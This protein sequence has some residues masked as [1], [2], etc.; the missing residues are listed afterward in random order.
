MNTNNLDIKNSIDEDISL[1]TLILK[2][3]DWWR[4]LVSRW[5]F[6]LIVGFIG[7]VLGLLYSIFNKPTFVATLTFV[8]EDDSKNGLGSLGGLAAMTGINL[9]GGGGGVF[10]GDNILELY[11]SRTMLTSALLNSSNRNDSLLIDRYIEVNN[12][13]QQWINNSS[14]RNLDFT[15]PKEDFSF[16]HDS[17]IGVFIEN[18]KENYLQ[19]KKPD[20]LLSLIEV[21]V[22]SPNERFSK[23][24]TEVL[25]QEVNNFYIQTKIKRASDNL[26]IIQYQV[27]S[28][29]R[30]LN[31]AISG[32]ASLSDANP[33]ANQALQALK[34]PSSKRQVDV[35]ANQAILSELVKNLEAARINLRR[36]TPLIQIIDKP[37]LPLKI[38]RIGKAKSMVYGGIIAV[39]FGLL[40]LCGRKY[41]NEIMKE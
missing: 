11:K 14:L 32:V 8:L 35:Q 20:K 31:S 29:R 36:E 41:F 18:I 4:Y 9:N 22:T 1:K 30:E 10:Q 37:I 2:I 7:G 33:N 39:F 17:L 25:V 5:L 38:E 3:I 21:K 15:I 24:F 27:D 23:D 19:I 16:Q 12:L 13:K 26:K 40:F 6:I 34:V 28:V